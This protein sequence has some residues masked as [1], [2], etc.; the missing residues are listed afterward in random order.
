MKEGRNHH[1]AG[2]QVG[3]W[4]ESRASAEEVAILS[5]WIVT[6]KV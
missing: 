6:C 4:D 5:S 3:T 2:M 1:E